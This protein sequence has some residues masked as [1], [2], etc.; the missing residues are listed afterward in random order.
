MAR[1][2]SSYKVTHKDGFDN[3]IIGQ[4]L[5]FEDS[6]LFVYKVN[7]VEIKKL[8]PTKEIGPYLKYRVFYK[9]DGEQNGRKFKGVAYEIPASV[10]FNYNGNLQ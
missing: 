2:T 9:N 3:F 4:D 8:V 6:L 1:R 5:L 10:I 7:D